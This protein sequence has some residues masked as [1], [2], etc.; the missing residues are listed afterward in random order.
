MSDATGPGPTEAPDPEDDDVSMERRCVVRRESADRDDLIRLVAD[1]EGLVHVDYRARLPG[2]GAYVTPERA[3]IETLE[4]KPGL[5]FKAL[6][7]T[8]R[9]EGLLQRVQEANRR[10]ARDA[11]SLAARSGS[12][13]GGKD[14]VRDLLMDPRTL[15]LMVASDASPRLVEDLRGRL[16]DRPMFTMWLDRD[17]LGEQV[18]KGARAALAIR[19]T[20]AGR[21]LVHELR[22]MDRLR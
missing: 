12:L 19:P 18:G 6:G 14:G 2:R 16:H 21:N 1:P 20:S 13:V 3:A 11:L 10:A 22:R 17:A 8:V 5:L 7:R 4:K 15:G 9:T